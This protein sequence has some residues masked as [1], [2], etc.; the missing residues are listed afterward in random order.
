MPTVELPNDISELPRTLPLV[1]IHGIVLM[2]RT[3]LPIPL[4]NDECH[5]LYQGHGYV[6]VLQS[7]CMPH[8]KEQFFR[9]GC[10]GRVVDMETVNHKLVLDIQGICRFDV[11]DVVNMTSPVGLVNYSKYK[12]DIKP[13]QEDK[14]ALFD[15]KRLIN[16]LKQYFHRTNVEANWEDIYRA[17][18]E[19]LVAA[20]SMFCP[21]E[22]GEKQA[23][24]E[25]PSIEAQSQLIMSLLEL[26]SWDLTTSRG[27]ATYH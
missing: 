4:T 13:I 14:P 10:L 8:Q 18:D 2:P 12:D 19:R 5:T 26:N 17:T 15:R 9:T 23:V 16:I 27:P 7:G 21:L 6:G 11:E 25:T 22:A 24:L 20:L 1:A 3:H